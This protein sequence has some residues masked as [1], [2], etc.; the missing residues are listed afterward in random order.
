MKLKSSGQVYKISADPLLFLLALGTKQWVGYQLPQL[1]GV[2][3]KSKFPMGKIHLQQ[4][5]Q[6]KLKIKENNCAIG[7]FHSL[8]LV[9]IEE[10]PS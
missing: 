2:L 10:G 9:S 5:L 3:E 6:N 4:Y 1:K 7:R 8:H